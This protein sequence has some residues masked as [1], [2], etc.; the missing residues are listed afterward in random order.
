MREKKTIWQLLSRY[1]RETG[2]VLGRKVK[3]K[4]VV[5]C[6]S[7]LPDLVTSFVHGWECEGE[8]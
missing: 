6:G 1:G 5:V 4:D 2:C 7:V 8:D 3:G